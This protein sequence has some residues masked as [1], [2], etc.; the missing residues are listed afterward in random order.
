[1]EHGALRHCPCHL[2]CVRRSATR[3]FL[4]SAD[5]CLALPRCWQQAMGYLGGRSQPEERGRRCRLQMWEGRHRRPGGG[6]RPAE[7]SRACCNSKKG[8]C[9]GGDGLS[10]CGSLAPGLPYLMWVEGHQR[11]PV[12]KRGWQHKDCCVPLVPIPFSPSPPNLFTRV[13]K[14]ASQSRGAG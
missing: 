2:S 7:M 8:G 1:M 11:A 5:P 4:I 13:Q 10:A 3:R 9:R 12:L 6:E 14:T